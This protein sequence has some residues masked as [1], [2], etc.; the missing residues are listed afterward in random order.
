MF[1]TFLLI[2]VVFLGFHIVEAKE[3]IC[4]YWLSQV[5]IETEVDFDVDETNPKNVVEGITC[6]LKFKG[7]KNKGL[8]GGATKD[9]VSQIFPA[10]SVEICALY[11]ASYLF[12]Q[13]WKHASAIALVDK[14]G[15]INSD[16]SVRKAY[17]SY[18]RWLKIIKKIG[19]EK[20]RE[21][22]LDPLGGSDVRWY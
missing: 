10:A 21:Q 18:E 2:M 3:D 12:Y 1:K 6:L 11:Y 5:D 4:K 13:D 14:D 8:F 20:A 22:K 19:L 15:V 7:N 16:K 17:K 9:T